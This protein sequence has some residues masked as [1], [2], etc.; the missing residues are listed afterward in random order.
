MKDDMK[1]AAT[2]AAF[3][4]RPTAVACSVGDGLPEEESDGE[5]HDGD[6]HGN[7]SCG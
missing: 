7:D 5:D 6:V 2:G 1:R 4:V 3:S